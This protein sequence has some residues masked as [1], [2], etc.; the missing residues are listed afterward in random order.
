[1]QICI[2]SSLLICNSYVR[3]S[4]GISLLLVLI[5][6][7]LEHK[8]AANLMSKGRMIIKFDEGVMIDN[9]ELSATI[10]HLNLSKQVTSSLRTLDAPRSP[11][12]TDQKLRAICNRY[13][14]VTA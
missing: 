5:A 11:S 3:C 13:F 7:D 8:F 1:L 14:D 6:K 10:A 12:M 2:E 9:V 4:G